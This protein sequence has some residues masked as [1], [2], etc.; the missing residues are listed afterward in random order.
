MARAGEQARWPIATTYSKLREYI[1]A[2]AIAVLAESKTDNSLA[3]SET[4]T[5]AHHAQV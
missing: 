4:D 2:V 1:P 3:E 5:L